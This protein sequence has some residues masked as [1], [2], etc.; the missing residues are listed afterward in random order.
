MDVE[1]TARAPVKRQA[2]RAQTAATCTSARRTGIISLL[3]PQAAR[4]DSTEIFPVGITAQ[5]PPKWRVMKT[6]ERARAAGDTSADARNIAMPPYIHLC[7][8]HRTCLIS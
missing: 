1:R 6:D 3:A 2:R 4:A 7:I 8:L 5:A